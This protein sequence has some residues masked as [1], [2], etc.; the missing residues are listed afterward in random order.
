MPAPLV[1]S[2]KALSRQHGVTLFMTL[3][4]AFQVLLT[5]SSEQDD[6]VIGTLTANRYRS[7]VENLIGLFTNIVVLRTDLSGNPRFAELLQRVRT[8]CL[9]AYA[10]PKVPF[11]QI[12]EFLQ[13]ARKQGRAPL[14]AMCVLEAPP[15]APV[16]VLGLR[17]EPVEIDSGTAKF[18]LSVAFSE[19]GSR[20]KGIVEYDTERFTAAAVESLV[21]QYRRILDAI[22]A[23]PE[24]RIADLASSTPEERYQV[25]DTWNATAA[26]YER[27]RCLH[28]LFEAQAARTPDAPAVEFETQALT[29][30]ELNR[31]ANQLAHFL[32]GLG[33][34]PETVVGI[35]L[36]RSAELMVCLLG[37]LKAGGVC[38]PLA[39]RD[40]QRRLAFLLADAH[41]SVVLT[42]QRWAPAFSDQ[43]VRTVCTDTERHVIEQQ[44][45]DAPVN[46]ATPHNLASIF[47]TSGSTGQPKGIMVQHGSVVNYTQAACHNYALRADDRV[48][49]FAPLGFD[50]ALEE[51]YPSWAAGAT[52]VLRTDAMLESCSTFL[53]A[54]KTRAVTVLNLPTAYWHE[55]T[56]ALE[57]DGLRLPRSV[58]LV[59]IGGEEALA[60]R[61]RAWRRAVKNDVRLVNTYGP[62]EAT[63]AVT[64][65]DLSKRT[66]A[67]SK[68]H[69][70]PIGRPIAN[71]RVYVLDA[72]LEPVPVGARGELYI[73]GEGLARGY[74][75]RPELTAQRFVADPFRAAPGAR[76]YRTGDVA[77]YLP[78]GNIEFIGRVDHQ[79]KVRG[80]RI[81]PGEIESLLSRHPAVRETLV[82]VNTDG[83]GEKRLVGY[84]VA[85][86]GHVLATG[87]LRRWLQEQLPLSLIPTAF[88][89][90][91]AMPRLRNGKVD[92]QALPAR[93]VVQ[94]HETFVAPR[95]PV[96]T[97]LAAIWAEL[98][99]LERV[100]VHDN[101]FE[102]GG[103]SLL[104]I[105]LV[106]RLP[107]V[108]SVTMSVRSVFEAP[109][110]AEFAELIDG[111]RAQGAAN[112]AHA[113]SAP[114]TI[115]PIPREPRRVP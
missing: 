70:V 101:F 48:L 61:L 27:E 13:P 20:C 59:I 14:Q 98:F 97:R 64:T 19:H 100:G 26:E 95:T 63:V 108:F 10:H 91:D 41:A 17:L 52:L 55:L 66:L 105:R 11:Q 30:G 40:P 56:A 58:R 106:S 3:F 23:Q 73:G 12:V 46:E 65:Y 99:R 50:A 4:A 72:G 6:L 25:L 90:L 114:P 68:L 37:V 34:R 21:R 81:E 9:G 35:C 109:T 60:V 78:D 115:V 107:R 16:D 51:L 92:R 57:R 2:L 44:R 67:A 45:S 29:Y 5:R 69:N 83:A 7:E 1:R 47:Y 84:V 80:V 38:L 82:L 15:P 93:D 103:H 32:R 36:E 75:G 43:T 62:T 53:E 113:A 74:V 8:V 96:E 28:Q 86:P 79:V 31:R 42:H 112:G 39:P 71:T 88:V 33:V 18:E 87:Q 77:R 94:Q 22:V 104:A 89:L 110:I 49:Q 76:M 24:Q 54:C 111:A 85:Q 102:L